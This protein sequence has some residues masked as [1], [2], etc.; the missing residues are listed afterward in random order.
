M[1]IL[2]NENI[3]NT[4]VQEDNNKYKNEIKNLDD[5]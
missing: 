3:I 2:L 1:L 5:T 4:R